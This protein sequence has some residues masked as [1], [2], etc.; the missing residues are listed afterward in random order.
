[1]E[2]VS[3][4]PE[5]H[6]L[7]SSHHHILQIR[8]GERADH[9]LHL[10]IEFPIKFDPPLTPLGLQQAKE[11][12]EY[13]LGYLK[14]HKFDEVRLDASP[15]LRTLMTAAGIA[16]VLGLPKIFVN[17]NFCEWMDMMFFDKNPLPEIMSRRPDIFPK[18]KIVE[19]YL[20]GID[21]EDTDYGIE[22]ALTYYPEN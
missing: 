22:E 5:D 14:T 15:F 16:K 4:K 6:I 12:G 17:H 19:E 7:T 21:F 3:G 20:Q 13:L 11:T 2:S 8:H 9:A 1:M 18:H 10:K